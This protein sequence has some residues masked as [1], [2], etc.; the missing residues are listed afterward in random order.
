MLYANSDDGSSALWV[1]NDDGVVI[2]NISY[3]IA[4]RAPILA[5]IN[6]H[7]GTSFTG[8]SDNEIGLH[9]GDTLPDWNAYE[10]IE[11]PVTKQYLA[12]NFSPWTAGYKENENVYLYGFESTGNI[13]VCNESGLVY[14]GP[15]ADFTNDLKT[16]L[17][18]KIENAG[19]QFNEFIVIE[20]PYTSGETIEN[21]ENYEKIS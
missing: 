18:S 11:M 19:I 3:S 9:F 1:L 5:Q 15:G 12:I 13:I 4:D 14:S 7:Y 10:K 16:S 17:R 20:T 21:W 8:W 2:D 6:E